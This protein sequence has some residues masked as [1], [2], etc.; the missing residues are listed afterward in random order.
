MFVNV[1]NPEPVIDPDKS[2]QSVPASFNIKVPRVASFELDKTPALL[3]DK[4]F[5][6]IKL[7]P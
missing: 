7:A 2:K 6:T 1:A 3:T 4:R 5:Y